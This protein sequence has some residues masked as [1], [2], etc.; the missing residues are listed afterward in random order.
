MFLFRKLRGRKRKEK[1][2]KKKKNEKRKGD[3]DETSNRSKPIEEVTT[4]EK[5]ESSGKE[6]KEGEERFEKK[7]ADKIG[8]M[9][10][11]GRYGVK[12]VK[13]KYT[14]AS[15]G[16]RY[17]RGEVVGVSSPSS[18]LGLRDGTY[19]Y[20]IRHHAFNSTPL[21]FIFV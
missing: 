11:I 2:K 16:I 8:K 17:L 6:E 5:Y 4:S 21:I 19:R 20:R 13:M 14:T 18:E 15:L 12:I 7:L 3:D 9:I 10:G 1:Q